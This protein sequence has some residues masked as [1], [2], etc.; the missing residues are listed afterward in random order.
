ML[1]YVAIRMRRF[2]KICDKEDGAE[3]EEEENA[4]SHHQ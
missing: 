1:E 3:V 4:N 2:K